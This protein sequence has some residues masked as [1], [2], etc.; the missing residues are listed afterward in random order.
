MQKLVRMVWFSVLALFATAALPQSPEMRDRRGF[1]QAELDQALAPIALYPDPLLS[2]I[3]MAATYPQDVYEAAAQ[4]RAN[5]LRGED[6]VRAVENAPWDPSVI[7]LA[8]FPEVLTLMDERRDW[9]E[10][11]GEAYIEQPEQVMDTIQELRR[12]A[13]AAG[14]LRSSD[15]LAVQRYDDRYIIESPS[16]EI[17]YVPYYDSRLVYGSWWW[18]DYQPVWWSPWSGYAYRGGYR[19]FGWGYGVRLSRGFFFGSM[20]WRN[21]YVRYSSHRPWYY[22]GGDYRQG[23]RWRHDRDHRNVVRDSRWRGFDRDVA[24]GERRQ[25]WQGER[26]D[27]WQGDRREGRENRDRGDNRGRGDRNDRDGRDR[28][29]Q[30]FPAPQF[31][32]RQGFFRP[33]PQAQNASAPAA[34]PAAPRYRRSTDGQR[35]SPAWGEGREARTFNAPRAAAIPQQAQT[36]HRAVPRRAP[37]AAPQRTEARA[38]NALERGAAPS[39]EHGNRSR[40]SGR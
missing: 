3:L 13:D 19:A 30:A 18:P 34:A 29:G 9:T 35:P 1:S 11:L 36:A 6:A 23:Y 7:S 33:Q 26:R 38:T 28:R 27:G 16:P 14:N 21:R 20:D 2:Q 5:G 15:E 31:A 22:R 39:R 40:E 12:R 10:R 8:A 4:A 25:D 32:S 24:R 17:V 37:E